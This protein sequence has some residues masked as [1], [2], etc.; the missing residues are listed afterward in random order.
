MGSDSQLAT[1]DSTSASLLARAAKH[2]EPAWQRIVDL[3]VPLVYGW[4]RHA[5]LQAS[6][7]SDLVQEVFRVVAQR[8]SLF[9]RE[10]PGDSFRAWLVGIT[11]NK[12]REHHRRQAHGAQPARG[13]ESFEELPQPAELTEES[14]D[15]SSARTFLM[16]KALQ[17]IQC[18]FEDSTWRA[19]WRS[20]IDNHS[21]AEIASDLGISNAGVRQAKYRVL[22]RLRRELEGLL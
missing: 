22:R 14:Q 11:R 16:R 17:A 12:L 1:S 7:A 9:R 3:Y 2:E 8:I 20:T 13:G 19:F 4:A 10:R 15:P 6:D 21:T 18:E 5:G